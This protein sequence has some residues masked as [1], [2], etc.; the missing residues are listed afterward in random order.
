[1]DLY[2]D[3]VVSVFTLRCIADFRY[4]FAVLQAVTAITVV[5]VVVGSACVSLFF[6]LFYCALEIVSVSFWTTTQKE[7]SIWR[8]QAQILERS[9]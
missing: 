6:F 3:Q 9:S 7:A 5:T 4:V 1:M 2:D 8:F